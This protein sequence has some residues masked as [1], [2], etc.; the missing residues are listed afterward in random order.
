MLPARGAMQNRQRG[1]A[2]ES[3]LKALTVSPQGDPFAS[4]VVT[5]VTLLAKLLMKPLNASFE[6]TPDIAHL[7]G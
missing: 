1:G 7:C 6:T 4:T 3:E 5:T 2:I